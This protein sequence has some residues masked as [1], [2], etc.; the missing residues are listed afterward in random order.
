MQLIAGSP[1]NRNYWVHR[2]TDSSMRWYNIE[3]EDNLTEDIL[4]NVCVINYKI[5]IGHL[6]DYKSQR[7]A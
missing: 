3:T 5:R 2:D 6:S 1:D 7:S 4:Y